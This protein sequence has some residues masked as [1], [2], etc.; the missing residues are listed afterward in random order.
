[1]WFSKKKKD[2]S[3]DVSGATP[4]RSPQEPLA[5]Q[6]LRRARE[7]LAQE[8]PRGFFAR[9]SQGISRTRENLVG[10]MKSLLAEAPV[11]DD[12]AFERLEE[13]LLSADCSVETALG[14]VQELR[15]RYEED[16]SLTPEQALAHV[17]ADLSKRISKNFTPM[18]LDHQPFA[19]IL[20]V[21]VNGVGKTTTIAKLAHIFKAYGK[22]IL[23]VA[24]DTFRAGAIEQLAT[25]GRRLDIEVRKGKPGGD[26]SGIVFDALQS[27][28]A[29]GFD[30]V[31]IDTA[32][33][34]HTQVN[35][36]EEIKKVRRV[37]Q[38]HVP[39]GPHETFLVLDATTGQN[40]LRQAEMFNQ[41]L[42]LS[43]LIL[44]KLDGTAKGGIVVSIVEKLDLPIRF[45]GVGEAVDD[46]QAFRGSEFMSALFG[47]AGPAGA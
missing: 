27:A 35:L 5:L 45:V 30:L 29:N 40:G 1:M 36:M 20:V 26:P 44:T 11:M 3:P 22:K 15:S 38:K 43:G 31:I 18:N 41:A 34:L 4:P 10:Q 32:G 21:G 8:A 12:V 33:R 9:L 17:R 24:G 42:D 7:E 14:I 46:L 47:D 23:L 19:V 39:D 6:K 25:W 2:S 16:P 28:E 37:V 13:L